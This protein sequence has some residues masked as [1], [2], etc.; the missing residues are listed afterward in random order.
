MHLLETISL[1]TCASPNDDA[2]T[3]RRANN[4]PL[5]DE[6]AMGGVC[7]TIREWAVRKVRRGSNHFKSVNIK[8]FSSTN[9]VADKSGSCSLWHYP[10]FIQS[11][12][13]LI[14]DI[15]KLSK[16]AE[17]HQIQPGHVQ[18]PFRW[19]RRTSFKIQRGTTFKIKLPKLLDFPS[20]L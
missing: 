12:G 9:I 16:F 17:F 5:Q 19:L 11:T 1:P 14:K 6:S 4:F 18:D 20:L 15:W 3:W 2:D 8:S 10:K 13:Y 7:S